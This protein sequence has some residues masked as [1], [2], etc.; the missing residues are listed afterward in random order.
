MNCRF[1]VRSALRC[2][3]FFAVAASLWSQPAAGTI[4]GRVLN[5][6]NGEYLEKA[7]VTVEGTRFETFTDATGVYRLNNVP[8]GTVLEGGGACST[9]S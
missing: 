1:P 2:L 8:A 5:T 6:R 4:E 7:R 9:K 3:P